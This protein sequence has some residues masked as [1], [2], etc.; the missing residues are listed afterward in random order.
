MI[1]PGE[2]RYSNDDQVSVVLAQSLGQGRRIESHVEGKQD[3]DRVNNI[4]VKIQI[5]F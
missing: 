1:A 5:Q 4:S 3:L 2:W